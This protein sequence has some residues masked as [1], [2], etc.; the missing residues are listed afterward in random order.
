M[1]KFMNFTTSKFGDMQAIEI[2]FDKND[3][4]FL[5]NYSD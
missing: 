4:Q 2:A 1:K 3:Y 5:F